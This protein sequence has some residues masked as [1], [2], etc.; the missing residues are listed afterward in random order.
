MPISTAN[1]QPQSTA[2]FPLLPNP[3]SSKFWKQNWTKE[4]LTNVFKYQG[5]GQG[6][7]PYGTGVP[8]KGY[9]DTFVIPYAEFT[10]P[11]GKPPKTFTGNYS[12]T[13]FKLLVSILDAHGVDG[14]EHV[15]DPHLGKYVPKGQRGK[16]D[17]AIEQEDEVIENMTENKKR[18]YEDTTEN[19]EEDAYPGETRIEYREPN[20][21]IKCLQKEMTKDNEIATVDTME[22][23][24]YEESIDSMNDIEVIEVKEEIPST[25]ESQ[26]FP[27]DIS[28]IEEPTECFEDQGTAVAAEDDSQMSITI[29]SAGHDP[30]QITLNRTRLKKRQGNC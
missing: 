13:M 18:T 12:D 24:K 22:N 27:I 2:Y 10:G 15:C 14:E 20:T 5:Y 25:N 21:K 3:I 1:T 29:H 30:V 4:Y 8:P 16:S 23:V 19:T 28:D 6:G 9:P 7:I 17:D 11:G 26:T